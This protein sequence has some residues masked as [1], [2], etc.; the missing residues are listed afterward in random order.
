GKL[1]A[2]SLLSVDSERFKR[3]GSA[4]E[5]ASPCSISATAVPGKGATL[6]PP[7]PLRTYL[8]V[9]LP[10][11]QTSHSRTPRGATGPR[12][13]QPR[14]RTGVPRPACPPFGRHSRSPRISEKS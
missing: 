14:L 7:P 2:R 4:A 10:T 5:L 3:S 12:V 6:P 1:G 13:P 11:A 8:Q 9:S